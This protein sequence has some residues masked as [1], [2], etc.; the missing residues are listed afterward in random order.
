MVGRIK[1]GSLKSVREKEKLLRGEVDAAEKWSNSAE[2]GV[3]APTDAEAQAVTSLSLVEMRDTMTRRKWTAVFVLSFC[4]QAIR[5]HKKV[6]CLA[7][8]MLKEAVREAVAADE[9]YAKN[10]TEQFPLLGIPVSIKEQV[11]VANTDNTAGLLSHCFKPAE[12]DAVTV[13]L[14]RSAGAVIFVKTTVPALLLSFECDSNVTGRTVNPHNTGHTPGGSSGGEG[15][16]IASQG[17]PLGIGTDIGGSIRIPAHFCGI[18]GL[19]PSMQ[20]L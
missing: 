8:V 15:A 11:G 18:C 12:R 20:R 5:A 19:K 17:S 16:L 2:D 10:A 14:L 1:G 13:Q 4:R 9:K 3:P 6:N 7:A